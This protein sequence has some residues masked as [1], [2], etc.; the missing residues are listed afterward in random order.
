MSRLPLRM[1]SMTWLL[2]A[3]L[4]LFLFWAFIFDLDQTVRTQGQLIP[5]TRTQVI[6]AA[7]G[8]V[9]EKVLVAEG[10]HVKAGQVLAVLESERAVAGVEEGRAKVAALSIGLARAR[11]EAAGQILTFPREFMAYRDLMAEQEQFYL[12][13]RRSL[14]AE[15]VS[16]E[17]AL[18]L[19]QDELGV[20]QR[21]FATGDTSK[22]DLMRAQRQVAEL[23]GKIESVRNKY[24]Q[25]ARQEATKL[26]DELASQRFKLDERRSVL[27]HTLLTTPVAGIVKSLRINTV[28]GVLKGGDELMQI[29]PTEVDLQVEVKILPAD[30]GLLAL[31]LPASIKIDAFDSSIYGALLGELE[32]VSSDTLLEQNAS[33]QSQ[34]YYRARVAFESAST[35][36]KLQLEQLKPGMTATVDIKTG[37][38]SVMTY[39]F[40][41]IVKAFSGA[42]RER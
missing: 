23:Q 42:A 13:K 28:G 32:Y 20:N 17:Q 16:L 35:N 22:L 19:A 36:P 11:A 2:L 37:Q 41:P 27:Q 4:T 7:D 3:V 39:L 15:L 5:S 33:G 10:E 38:R 8:G 30:I 25:D 24:L 18:T 31:G 21:L 34:T 14:D 9:L 29:S 12:Q 26:Q 6:Q 1:P 40:K